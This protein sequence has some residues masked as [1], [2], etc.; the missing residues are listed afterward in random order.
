MTGRPSP[1]LRTWPILGQQ[2]AG[3]PWVPGTPGE[4]PCE[5]HY[6]SSYRL[7]ALA[8]RAVVALAVVA[9][10]ATALAVV[11]DFR[12]GA[13][14]LAAPAVDLRAVALA[15]ADFSAL[16]AVAFLAG[17]AAFL[18]VALAGAALADLA[19]LLAAL[20]APRA[21]ALAVALA[22]AFLAADFLELSSDF[23]PAA[24]LKR[25]PLDAGIFTGAPVR[26]LRPVR[27]LWEVGTKLPKP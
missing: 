10:V 12:A 23:S 3:R 20:V 27:A 11:A 13:T 6:R 18:V 17:T 2:L 5:Q 15:G 22:A 24:G 9:R 4:G 25:I 19:A 1:G 7:E 16:A 26:G 21:A 8:D 14:F